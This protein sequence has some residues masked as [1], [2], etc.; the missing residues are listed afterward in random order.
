MKKNVLDYYLDPIVK[1]YVNFEWRAT[2]KEFWMF[3]LFHSIIV[4]L[5]SFIWGLI[6]FPFL[7]NIYALIIFLPWLAISVRRLHDVGK[8][9][10]WVF[11][12]LVPVIWIVRIFILLLG[13]SDWDNQYW[14]S[15][16]VVDNIEK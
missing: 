7:Y 3:T 1:N 8:S 6:H 4:V 12:P 14:K 11:I 5:L 2:I 10:W 15:T 13:Y 9:G 16:K